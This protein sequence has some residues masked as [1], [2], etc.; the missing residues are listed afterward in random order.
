MQNQQN[1]L[2]SRAKRI[3]VA[4]MVDWTTPDFRQFARLFNPF[5]YLYTEMV[6]TSAILQGDTAHQ[7]RF[8][9]NEPPLVLQLG[10]NSPNE[11]AQ[12][13]I[14]GE[15]FGYSEINLN[16]GCP[17]DRV[18]EGSI[19]AC[20]MK[21]P[22][23]VGDCVKAMRQAC[24]LPI[25]V[26]HRI[27][28]DS[29][30]SYEFMADF[31]ATVADAGCRHFIVHA[32]TAWL[33]GLSP[34]QN[35]EIPPLRYDDVYRLKQDFPHLFIEI[36]GGIKT[37][38]EVQSHLNFVDGVMIGRE[39]YHNP[40]LLAQLNTLWGKPVPSHRQI[41]ETLIYQLDKECP[42]LTAVSRHYLG[43]FF[44][45]AG[46]R[47]WRQSLSGQKTLSLAQIRQAGEQVLQKNGL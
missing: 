35:R 37:V 31:V 44:G 16:V 11:L 22:A 15:R 21:T 25:T 27:G 42:V 19:G 26:K 46:A 12:C 43:L 17:S 24:D 29:F 8:Y 34:K 45:L 14:L 39:A 10:G 47:I 20:L 6:S 36:N 30:D 1:A 33:K 9:D 4:P 23:H 18:Q 2:K 5:V 3:S 13:A 32:R 28:V 7:L 38:D 40:Y 41:F